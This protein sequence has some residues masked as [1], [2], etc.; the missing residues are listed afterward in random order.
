MVQSL[1]KTVWRCLSKQKLELPYEAAIPLPE[2]FLKKVKTLIHKGMF[3]LIFIAASFIIAK[4]W[5]QLTFSS[6]D[7]WIIRCD[8]YTQWN[9]SH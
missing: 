5:K 8:V 1:R 4:I 6:T 3:T 2:V 7:G 9:I